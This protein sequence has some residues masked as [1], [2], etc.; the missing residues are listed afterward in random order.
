MQIRELGEQG[1]LKRL[2]SF[3][4]EQVVGDDAALVTVPDDHQLVVTTDV[5][6]DGIHFSWGMVD[7]TVQTT[8]PYDAGWRAAAANLSDIAAMGANPLGITV[9]LSLPPTLPVADIEAFYRG[10]QDCLAPF[11]TSIVG[12]DVC[13]SSVMTVAIAAYGAVLPEHA[14]RRSTA[15]PGDVI[16]VTGVHGASR[17]GLELL[18]Y[19]ERGTGLR[20]SDRQVLHRAHQRPQPR[21]DVVGAIAQL[22]QAAGADSGK[23]NPGKTNPGKTN[24]GKTSFDKTIFGKTRISGMDSS[25]GL[26]DAV[27][28]VCRASQVG[29]VLDRSAIPIA[30]QVLHWQSS[31]QAMHW[32][33]YGGED[34]ELVLCCEAAIAQILIQRL[35]SPAYVIGQI[36]KE[37]D[38]VLSDPSGTLEDEI[39]EFEHGFQ[40]F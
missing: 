22:R 31:Q 38:V 12:G 23:T 16:M 24:P 27:L 25:D 36:T 10:L 11:D 20:E 19:P 39:L 33:L 6:V 8:S 7:P 1:L 29:A 3:C 32:A 21:L 13:R 4:P 26:A 17:A 2:Q 34:F 35:T 9:G 37:N 14:I 18:L 5:L 28:Q 40:H 30:P 15:Q